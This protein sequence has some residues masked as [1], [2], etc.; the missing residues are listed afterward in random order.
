M[1]LCRL[2]M[3]AVTLYNMNNVDDD[4][5]DKW[6]LH[7]I[8]VMLK[9]RL[10][11]IIDCYD[12]DMIDK[13]VQVVNSAVKE[14]KNLLLLMHHKM[15]RN[16]LLNWVAQLLKHLAIVTILILN[17]VVLTDVVAD[18]FWIVKT[19]ERI[20]FVVDV[21]TTMWH[22]GGVSMSEQE[23]K[24]IAESTMLWSD[25]IFESWGENRIEVQCVWW[26]YCRREI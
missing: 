12:D 1:N 22:W 4:I 15:T 10:M 7:M 13:C 5:L 23:S 21:T 14:C 19:T 9:L 18:M 24:E 8:E 11:N 3:T 26:C 6:C 25:D 2:A 20:Q 16:F 17:N